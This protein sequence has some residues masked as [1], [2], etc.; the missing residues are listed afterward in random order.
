MGSRKPSIPGTHLPL[1]HLNRFPEGPS[2]FPPIS[3]KSEHY[4]IFTNLLLLEQARIGPLTQLLRRGPLLPV[5]TKP[6]HARGD[7]PG[8]TI[9]ENC[10]SRSMSCHFA[11]PGLIHQAPSAPVRASIP[12]ESPLQAPASCRRSSFRLFLSGKNGPG[13]PR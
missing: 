4:Q 5:P 6:T 10:R 11:G 13:N 1:F 7:S 12:A 2:N 9:S 3:E 8:V